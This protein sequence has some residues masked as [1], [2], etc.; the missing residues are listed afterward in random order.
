MPVEPT[1]EQLRTACNTHAIQ[2]AKANN[3][4]TK[5]LWFYSAECAL[6]SLYIKTQNLPKFEKSHAGKFG[7]KLDKLLRECGIPNTN[8]SSTTINETTYPIK[9][10]HEC[11]RYGVSIPPE[12][13]ISQLKY[14]K[15][16]VS[17]VKKLL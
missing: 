4:S 2:A 3:I 17:D 6:K 8:S 14:L 1:R 16:I 15:K 7:H 11:M 5:L 9:E 12:I 10:F 13:E